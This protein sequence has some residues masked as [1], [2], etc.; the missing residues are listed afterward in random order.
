MDKK[1]AILN[2]FEE[3]ARADKEYYRSL[4]PRERLA[5]LLELNRRW[6]MRNDGEASERL[7]RVYRI[8]KLS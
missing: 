1:I 6:P 4:S 2:S 5:I 3:A 8:A 7:T